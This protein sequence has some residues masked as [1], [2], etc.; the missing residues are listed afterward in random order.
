MKSPV[1]SVTFF[2]R[3]HMNEDF[4][5]LSNMPGQLIWVLWSQKIGAS[6]RGANWKVQCQSHVCVTYV[7]SKGL[8]KNIDSP[9]SMK[10]RLLALENILSHCDPLTGGATLLE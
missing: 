1:K 10:L 2:K 4:L 3:E 6:L 9:M 5:F 7:I 8:L